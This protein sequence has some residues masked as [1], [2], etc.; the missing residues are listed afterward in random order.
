MR[1][2][3]ERGFV[4][5]RWKQK[6]MPYVFLTPFLVLSIIFTLGP[7]LYALW[8]SFH[9]MSFLNLSN[10]TYVE[11]SN[12]ESVMQDKVF[13]QAIMNNLKLIVIAVP[14]IIGIS[15]GLAILLNSKIKCKSFFR[16]A[17]Y[18]PYVVSPIAMGV[19][20][21]QLFS[22]DSFI[23]QSLAKLGMEEVSWYTVMP[24]AFWLIVL[25][26]VWTQIGFY[27]VL[28]LNGLQN[29]STEYYE[30]SKLDGATRWQQFRYITLPL[31][32]PTTY[33]VVFMCMVSVLQIFDQPYVIS[34]TGGASAGSPGDGTLTMVMYIY[35][36][37]FRYREMGQASAA[38][39]IVFLM[40]FGV[41][42]VQNLIFGRE[43]K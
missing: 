8:I 30:A 14:L 7:M 26:V 1:S 27:M 19:I 40:I 18:F 16:S 28:Y 21:V 41:S 31:L 12:Y 4:M 2:M 39:F 35:E 43:E 11:F 3:K 6:I 23:V 25:I 33:L 38:A 13:V 32:K 42:L 29:I 37:A 9:E 15:L 10:S 20:I 22:K 36:E 5:R 17:Y 34:T 24:Y